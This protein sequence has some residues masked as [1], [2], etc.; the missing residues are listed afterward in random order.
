M[1]MQS[2]FG[3]LSLKFNSSPENVA[4]EALLYILKQHKE[5]WPALHRHFL[6]TGIELPIDVIFRSQAW[7][8][9]QSQPDLIAIDRDGDPVLIIEAKFWAGLTPN[10]PITYLQRLVP[11]KPGL[12]SFVCPGMRLST[13]WEKL[14]NRCKEGGMHLDQYLDL[15]VEFRSA[16]LSS[17]HALCA[18]SWGALLSVLRREAEVLGNDMLLGDTNQLDGLCSRMDTEAFLP[19]NPQDISTEIGRRVQHFANLVDYVVYELAANHGADI[20]GLTTGG[21]QSAYGRYFKLIGFGMFLQYSPR[22]WSRY[23]ETPIWLDVKEIIEEKWSIT[24]SVIDGIDQLPQG[25]FRRIP[26]TESKNTIGLE[27]PLGVEQPDV[28][29]DVIGQI[30][31]VAECCASW[32]SKTRVEADAT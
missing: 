21:S 13:L 11:N 23:G 26:E 17:P 7:G 15:D 5:A 9:D 10:Q 4:T 19:L 1:E 32:E 8:E 14:S 12:L 6:R 30:K 3:E 16:R 29:A 25:K 28:I 2:L 22:L 20:A 24:R 18:I 31:Q 27:L